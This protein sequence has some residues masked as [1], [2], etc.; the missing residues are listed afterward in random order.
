MASGGT[1]TNKMKPNDLMNFFIEEAQHCVINAEHSADGG[2]VLAVQGKK[3][4]HSYGNKREKSKSGVS[5]ENCSKPGHTKPDCYSKGGG[6]EGQWLKQKDH[7]KGAKKMDESAAGAETED[8]ELF[9][10]TCTSDYTS[11]AN[12]LQLL[13]DQYG[14]CIDSGSSSHYCPDQNK[15]ENY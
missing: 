3:G 12:A 2:S 10:F 8:E 14:A 13:K 11:L 9:A 5:C 4:K 7:K 15:F 6:K 1:S